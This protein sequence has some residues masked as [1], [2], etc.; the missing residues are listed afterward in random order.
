MQRFLFLYPDEPTRKIVNQSRELLAEHEIEVL[1]A[2]SDL[3]SKS[4]LH[5]PEYTRVDQ[6]VDTVLSYK[7]DGLIVQTEYALLPGAVLCEKLG[8]PGISL[9][10]ALIC[11]NKWLCREILAQHDITGPSY[12]LAEGANQVNQF[13]FFPVVLKGIA[14][15]L[16]RNV[17]MVNSPS[18]LDDR[19]KEL[20]SQLLESP[21]IGRLLSFAKLTGLDLGCDPSRQFL[22]EEYLNGHQYET[23]GLVYGQVVDIFGVTEPVITEP[24][25]IYFEGYMLPADRHPSLEVLTTS[26][27]RAIGLTN[28]GFSIEFRDEKLIEVNAR[29]GEDNGFP[30]LFKIVR[31]QYAIVDWLEYLSGRMPPLRSAQCR[32]ALGYAN[33]YRRGVVLGIPEARDGVEIVVHTGQVIETPPYP[34]INP[35]LAY[36]IAT[37]ESSSQLAYTCARAAVDGLDFDVEVIPER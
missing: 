15:T 5:L 11:T 17:V 24:P 26:I 18:E 4:D 12:M 33:Y 3:N 19:V 7:F 31:G 30:D 27:I 35:H 32:A 13:G 21:D 16:G 20:K 8:L 34:E 28:A 36:A 9:S 14:T 22:V 25:R 37:H 10:A 6:V 23:D 29:L 1:F 2:D